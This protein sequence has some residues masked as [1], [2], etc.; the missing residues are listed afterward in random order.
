M[1]PEPWQGGEPGEQQEGVFDLST[2]A[3]EL[4]EAARNDLQRKASRLVIHGTTQRAVL[5]AI[6]AGGGLAEHAS[7]PAA[8]LHV[9]RGR[10]RL[11]AGDAAEWFVSAGQVVAIPPERHSVDALED[12]AFL[13]TVALA[14]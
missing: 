2:L 7:P 10:I 9:L 1:T 3:D 5:M 4:L 11:Y 13:L 6:L 8:T 12:S 14:N